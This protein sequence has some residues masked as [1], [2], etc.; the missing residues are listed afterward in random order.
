MNDKFGD[1]GSGKTYKT[2]T[3]ASTS[4]MA[5]ESSSGAGTGNIAEMMWFLLE[6]QQRRDE[7]MR[8]ERGQR[9]RQLAEERERKDKEMAEERRRHE[10][11][12]ALLR[13]LLEGAQRRDEA[14]AARRG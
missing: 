11:E 1:D 7:E 9:E 10:E 4:T 5:D 12:M 2:I 3:A 8:E 14:A 6:D 13:G